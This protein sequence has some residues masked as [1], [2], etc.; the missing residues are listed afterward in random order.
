M[1]TVEKS[2]F[3]LS[4]PLPPSLLSPS[5][6]HSSA[7]GGVGLAAVQIGKACGAIVIA[8]ARGAK[9]VHI[10]KSLGVDH[11]VDLGSEN[12]IE[13]VKEFLKARR[14]KDGSHA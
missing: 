1:L 10:L 14:L 12:V 3:S 13:S 5:C 11:V 4:H 7:P 2:D 9:K 6:S 8:V